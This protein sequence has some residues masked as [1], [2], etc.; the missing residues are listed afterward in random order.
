M[1]ALER[2]RGRMPQPP[3]A[4]IALLLVLAGAAIGIAGALFSGDEAGARSVP[5]ARFAD[6]PHGRPDSGRTRDAESGGGLGLRL[7]DN[8]GSAPLRGPAALVLWCTR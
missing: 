2:L 6:H 1:V 7:C 4:R 8:T 5:R 3:L